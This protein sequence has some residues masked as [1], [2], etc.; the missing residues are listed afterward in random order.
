VIQP[1]SPWVGTC[2]GGDGVSSA[3]G[4]FAAARFV[5]RFLG[6]ASKA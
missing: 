3:R 6:M 2:A 4:D 1:Y 5:V